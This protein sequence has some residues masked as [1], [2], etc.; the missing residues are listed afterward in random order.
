MKR[1]LNQKKIIVISAP[2]GTGKTTV[3]KKLLERNKDI[4]FSIS[5]TTRKIRENE[6]DGVDYY[7]VSEEKF[8]E[9]IEKNEFLEWAVVHSNYY[10][11]T[12]REIERII[13]KGFCIL[14]IDVQGLKNIISIYPDIKSIFLLP[15]S[16][17]ELEKRLRQRGDMDEESIRLRLNNAREELKMIY[18]YKFFV[19]NETIDETVKKV[20]KIIYEI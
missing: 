3:V 12:K 16:I 18:L 19:V 4:Y 7:F 13:E 14:D 17:Y 11:T 6:K 1:D 9:M 8:K 5:T 2:S 20:E 10:G 15:P